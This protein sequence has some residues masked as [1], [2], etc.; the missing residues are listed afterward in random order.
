MS[1][2][3]YGPGKIWIAEYVPPTRWQRVKWFLQFNIFWPLTREGR[4]WKKIK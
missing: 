4:Q 2:P 3:R 1:A